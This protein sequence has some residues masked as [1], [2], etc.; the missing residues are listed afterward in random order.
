MPES[1]PRRPL[2]LLGQ[3]GGG[4]SRA[5]CALRCGD[6]CFHP[7]PN[8]SANPYFGDIFQKALSRR[9]ALRAGAVGAGVSAL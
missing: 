6:A 8:T 5:T 3:V 1:A 4:R 9:S 2:P 7:A